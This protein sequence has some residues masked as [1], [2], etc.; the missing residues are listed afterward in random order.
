MSV[1]FRALVGLYLLGGIGERIG[2][3]EPALRVGIADLDREPV[4]GADDV[5]GPLR[6]ARGHVL[7][8]GDEPVHL[9]RRLEVRQGLED[10]EDGRGPRHVV[11]HPQHAVGG[12]EVE[13]AGVE[14]DAL[15]MTATRR[16]GRP[17]GT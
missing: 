14:R 16:R 17:L 5:A 1:P 13:P 11:L 15:P 3:G 7:R 2:E 4:H 12:L 6:R 9:D 8:R 10:A